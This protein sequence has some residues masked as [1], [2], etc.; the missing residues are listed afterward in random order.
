MSPMSPIPPV[1]QNHE[2]NMQENTGVILGT[3]DIMTPVNKMSPVDN[4]EKHAQNTDIGDTGDTGDTGDIFPI[5]REEAKARGG[6]TE[7]R[8]STGTKLEP[9][10]K[11]AQGILQEQQQQQLNHNYSA[12]YSCYY[13]NNNF[14][15]DIEEDYKRHV[16][17]IHPGKLCYPSKADLDIY[18]GDTRKR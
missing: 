13:C 14:E 1:G 6:R 5:S 16:I 18:N 8:Q 9:C 2:G 17:K 4:G 7:E 3:G 10:V 15:T 12:V 11:F